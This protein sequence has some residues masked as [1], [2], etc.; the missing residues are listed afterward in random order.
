[1]TSPKSFAKNVHFHKIIRVPGEWQN[2]N[3]QTHFWDF[4]EIAKKTGTIGKV[5]LTNT[6]HFRNLSKFS[7]PRRIREGVKKSQVPKVFQN[8][9][10]F[11]IQSESRH[12]TT[13][14]V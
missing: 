6:P 11:A 7:R 2:A 10:V 8:M 4:F 3:L 1:M 5:S 12:S 9:P 14:L 13:T